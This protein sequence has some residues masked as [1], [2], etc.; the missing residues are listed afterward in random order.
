MRQVS[1]T[2]DMMQ[3]VGRIA[4]RNF[5]VDPEKIGVSLESYPHTIKIVG[6]DTK[7]E[8]LPE[9]ILKLKLEQS[10]K[11]FLVYHD[12]RLGI[13]PAIRLTVGG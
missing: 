2:Y 7:T 12:S 6:V 5:V 11:G 8:F 10:G 4:D 9:R 3:R 1:M 13:Y